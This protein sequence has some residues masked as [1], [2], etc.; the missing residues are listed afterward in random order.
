MLFGC[1]HQNTH[2]SVVTKNARRINHTIKCKVRCRECSRRWSMNP[3]LDLEQNTECIRLAE[4]SG[5]DHEVIA[6]Y[7]VFADGDMSTVQAMLQEWGEE[8]PCD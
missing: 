4:A 7:M 3:T 6:R 1:Y 2:I 5:F 8:M